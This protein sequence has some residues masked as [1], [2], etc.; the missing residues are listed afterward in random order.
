MASATGLGEDLEL[1]LERKRT[2]LHSMRASDGVLDKLSDHIQRTAADAAVASLQRDDPYHT[3]TL[4]GQ[5]ILVTGSSGYVGKAFCL[6]LRKLGAVPIGLDIVAGDTVDFEGD[7][8]DSGKVR[9]AMKGCNGV[10]HTAALHAPHATHH[11]ESAFIATNVTG[12]QNILDAAVDA[13][14]IPV[15]HTS[16]TSLTITKN[17]KKSEKSGKIVWLDATSQSPTLSAKEASSDPDDAPRNKYGRTKLEGERRCV[18]AAQAGLPCVIVR[19]SRCFPED[20]LPD[21][22]IPGETPADTANVKANELLGRRVALVDVI[23]G[24]LR[25]LTR[26]SD[27]AIIGKVLTLSAPF[28]FTRSEMPTESAEF[29]GFLQEHRPDLWGLYKKL[30]WSMPFSL[31]RVYDTKLA[32]QLLDWRPLVTFDFLMEALSGGNEPTITGEDARLGRY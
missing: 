27:P 11:H 21:S 15:I 1:R 18:A 31:R 28:P 32:V 20:L 22:I 29:A 24:H 5:R 7:V 25:A 9:E 12:T 10:L 19:I 2:D 8:S 16:T 17:V 23:T 3:G 14:K 26:A 30:G 6:A 13:G 4:S